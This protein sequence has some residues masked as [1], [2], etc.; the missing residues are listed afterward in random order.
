LPPPP[1]DEKTN[2]PV[3]SAG[4][5][6]GEPSYTVLPPGSSMAD[7]R[8]VA[9]PQGAVPKGGGAKAARRT[10]IRLRGGAGGARKPLPSHDAAGSTFGL[11]PGSSVSDPKYSFSL[12]D[13]VYS[14]DPK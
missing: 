12:K 1:N 14:V 13:P 9:P 3:S 2:T 5:A 4:A 10:L 8:Y 6:S 11:P 7:P